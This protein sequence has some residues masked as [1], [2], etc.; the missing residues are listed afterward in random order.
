MPQDNYIDPN[1]FKSFLQLDDLKGSFKEELGRLE[2]EQ[3]P[4]VDI[5]DEFPEKDGD[6]FDFD[7]DLLG[8][9][10]ELKFEDEDGWEDREEEGEVEEDEEDSSEAE[11]QEEEDSSD[12]G[13][14]E[15][16]GK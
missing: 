2:S 7:T 1:D 3:E 13:G 4:E 5:D 6:D 8:E 11:E 14:V 15:R 10:D 9:S 16:K 12:A